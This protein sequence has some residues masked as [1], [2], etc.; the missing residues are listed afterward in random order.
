MMNVCKQAWTFF[1]AK[2]L[3]FAPH[4]FFVHLL[5]MLFQKTKCQFVILF[6]GNGQLG[7]Y[8]RPDAPSCLIGRIRTFFVDG[9][10]ICCATISI[11]RL[12]I[13]SH[14]HT[15]EVYA[16]ACKKTVWVFWGCFFCREL[17]IFKRIR[18]PESS[19]STNWECFLGRIVGLILVKPVTETS[20]SILITDHRHFLLKI[21]WW[22]LGLH[23]C[24]GF[25]S[26]VVTAAQ[27]FPF[28]VGAAFRSNATVYDPV[29][30]ELDVD[31]GMGVSKN[32]TCG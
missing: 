23:F 17:H 29:P 8:Y 15:L 14:T 24:A 12:L 19:V 27:Q 9:G 30:F 31:S 18:F 28:R 5:P 1:V 32:K 25:K 11:W 3:G 2:T 4:I 10:K 22:V 26:V 13:L 21:C 6:H 16:E 20:D 7:R